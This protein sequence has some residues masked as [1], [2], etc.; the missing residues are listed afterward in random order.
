MELTV[1]GNN[2]A[3]SIAT[4]GDP[5]ANPEKAFRTTLLKTISVFFWPMV[6]LVY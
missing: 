3:G 2:A 1:V 6:F 4:E 5:L